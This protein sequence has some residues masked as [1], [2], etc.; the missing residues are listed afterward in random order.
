MRLATK[1]KREIDEA[2]RREWIGDDDVLKE[3]FEI[4]VTQGR[5]ELTYKVSIDGSANIDH[6]A[7]QAAL[8][9]ALLKCTTNKP[10]S[11][12]SGSDNAAP[13]RLPERPRTATGIALPTEIINTIPGHLKSDR[14]IRSLTAF[15]ACSRYAYQL[16]RPMIYSELTV[17]LYG[18]R[19]NR[20]F[21][22]LP[23]AGLANRWHRAYDNEEDSKI[24][25]ENFRSSMAVDCDLARRATA[26][27]QHGQGD[28][29]FALDGPKR[30]RYNLRDVEV[31]RLVE[32]CSS[33]VSAFH[34]AWGQPEQLE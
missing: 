1:R 10:S 9:N 33:R 17:S 13:S 2:E 28:L 16:A 25:L 26:D 8:H 23:T 20:M 4:D 31:M 6:T 30:L 5:Q 22:Y 12:S 29:W 7:I 27:L 34:S 11:L 14:Q 21:T 18:L 32:V 24:I 19:K 3:T 15:Q